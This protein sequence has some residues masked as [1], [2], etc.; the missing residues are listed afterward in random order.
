MGGAAVETGDKVPRGTNG[1]SQANHTTLAREPMM[2][3]NTVR[4][5]EGIDTMRF[6]FLSIFAALIL[7][8]ACESTPKEGSD[9]MGSGQQAAPVAGPTPGTQ[10]DLVVNVGD[11]V[12]F[13]YDQYDVQ[14]DA[15][16][17]L[18]RVAAWLNTNPS[19]TLTIEGHADE[20]GTREYNLALSDRRAT[21]VRDYL[22]ALGVSSSRLRTV[23]YG[24]ERP[25]VLGSNE[26]SWAQNRRAV[27]LVN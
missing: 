11:R 12:F 10:E 13:G 9:S 24:E 20:R 8:T 26:A 5:Y 18:D 19:V 27:F 3:S 7:L 1:L 21:S 6:K 14:S 23:S 4:G 17:T 15:R 2:G 16:A 25:A 22:T